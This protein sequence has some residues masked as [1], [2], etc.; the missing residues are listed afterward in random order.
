MGS[1][2]TTVTAY[3]VNHRAGFLAASVKITSSREFISREKNN[4]EGY[5][6]SDERQSRPVARRALL[7]V[8]FLLGA[9]RREYPLFTCAGLPQRFCDPLRPGIHNRCQ[10]V[11]RFDFFVFELTLSRFRGVEDLLCR[12]R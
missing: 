5:S 1:L 9:Q 11:Q 12:R 10:Q 3:L 8:V 6:N 2:Y 4:Q 7:F